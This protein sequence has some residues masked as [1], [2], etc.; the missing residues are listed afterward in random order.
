M[1]TVWD[2]GE[3]EDENGQYFCV[4]CSAKEQER[5]P[6]TAPAQERGFLSLF[7]Q[8]VVNNLDCNDSRSRGDI[9]LPC[10]GSWSKRAAKRDKQSDADDPTARVAELDPRA[11]VAY[12]IADGNGMGTWFSACKTPKVM[13]KLSNAMPDVL[14]QSLT[15][16]AQ[17]LLK[18]VGEQR[19]QSNKIEFPILPLILGGD[20][21]FALLPAP[22]AID[23]AARFCRE[24][25]SRMRSVIDEAQSELEI[26]RQDPGYPTISAAVV[27][28]K[29]NYP[30]S[31][32]HRR[33]EAL[34]KS[35]KRLARRLEMEQ[36]R[37]RYSTLIFDVVV[38]NPSQ[39][40]RPSSERPYRAS[41]GP[42]FVLDEKAEGSLPP[43]LGLSIETLLEQ[44]RSLAGLPGKRHS[45][46]EQLY[47]DCP[48]NASGARQWLDRQ[49]FLLERTGRWQELNATIQ[50]AMSALGDSATGYW[51]DIKRPGD[52]ASKPIEFK[53]NALPD[54]LDGWSFL[55]RVDTPLAS[56]QTRED[57]EAR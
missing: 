18:R 4:T 10:D 3:G 55:H 31:L 26:N 1:A 45:Q 20:D 17:E 43:S 24:Y 8:A 51:R 57:V 33:G 50:Q 15:V 5:Q 9:V 21:L 54:V 29:K 46:L 38:G 52:T 37:R 14:R 49:E 28:C 30:Y 27:I 6:Q 44:R 34:M 13:R 35:A 47:D 22:W 41:L 16:A 48:T 12:L 23:L 19:R 11:Y 39:G 56:Y 2:A 53:G 36:E 40:E 25:E 42:Y 32:A 7:R